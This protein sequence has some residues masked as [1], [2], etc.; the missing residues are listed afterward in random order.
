MIIAFFQYFAQHKLM[1][2]VRTKSVLQTESLN[3]Q[4]SYVDYLK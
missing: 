4:V 3:I 1:T 2:V